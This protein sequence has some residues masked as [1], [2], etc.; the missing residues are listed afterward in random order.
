MAKPKKNGEAKK[1]WLGQRKMT[2]PR[3]DGEAK[4]RWRGKGKMASFE[5]LNPIYLFPS[6]SKSSVIPIT[7]IG[8]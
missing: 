5:G 6:R 4:V 7:I 8:L 1:R 2:R 3:K